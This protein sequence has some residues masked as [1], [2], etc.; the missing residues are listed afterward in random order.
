MEERKRKDHIDDLRE[1]GRW[2][3]AKK[4]NNGSKRD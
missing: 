1:L 3:L 4:E 2:I